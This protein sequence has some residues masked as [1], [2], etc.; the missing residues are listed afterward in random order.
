MPTSHIEAKSQPTRSSANTVKSVS[1]EKTVPTCKKCG[2]RLSVLHLCVPARKNKTND[3]NKQT[4]STDLPSTLPSP[5]EKFTPTCK[6]CGKQHWPLD[7]SCIGRKKARAEAKA[8]ARAEAEERRRARAAAIARAKTE[9]KAR[10]QAKKMVKAEARVRAKAERKARAEA[11]KW[12]RIEAKRAKADAEKEKAESEKAKAQAE[13]KAASAEKARTE[14]VSALFETTPNQVHPPSLAA[15]KPAP[16]STSVLLGICA[17]DIMET[18]VLWA[19][20]ENSVQQVLTEMQQHDAA[21]VVIGR[22]AVAEGLVSKADL[23]GRLSPHLQPVFAKWQRPAGDITLHIK[24]RWV[25][26]TPVRT[27]S[28]DTPLAAIMATMRQFG[29]GRL[30]VTDQQGKLQG[31]VTAYNI[32]KIKA[33]LKLET[34][35]N[36][37]AVAQEPCLCNSNIPPISPR[38]DPNTT[39]TLC[40]HCD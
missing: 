24:I 1:T 40:A 17:K 13:A 31:V 4:L 25:M 5:Y 26:T 21:Y 8:K 2:N 12:T 22:G 10:A 18:N 19:D 28:A 16:N 7:P 39:P 35:P 32:L 6:F 15:Q 11:K 27:I 20:P 30:P 14:K 29:A 36:I 37:S 38:D 23:T 33:L 3:S 34:S 9:K